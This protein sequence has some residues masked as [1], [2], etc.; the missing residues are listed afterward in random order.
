MGLVLGYKC[1]DQEESKKGC[2][3]KGDCAL[4][5]ALD[6]AVATIQHCQIMEKRGNSV[7]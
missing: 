1:I 5:C 2:F 3:Y 6:D 4:D 7:M